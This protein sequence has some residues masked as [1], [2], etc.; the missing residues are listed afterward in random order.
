MRKKR[1]MIVGPRGSGKTTL[2]N[3]LN[4][5][6]GAIRKTQDI[7]YGKF[8]IDIPSSYI[9]NTWMYK[10]LIALSQDASHVLLLVDQSNSGDVYSPGFAR[11]FTCPVVGVITKSDLKQ[12]NEVLCCKQ[13]KNIGV[14]EPYYKV[15]PVFG[16][17]I[18]ILKKQLSLP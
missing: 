17:G 7:I 9:E 16:V 13:L 12:E 15:S 4:D 8:T 5:Y 1:I 3:L 11:V 14:P 2:A 10:H 6:D 18:D